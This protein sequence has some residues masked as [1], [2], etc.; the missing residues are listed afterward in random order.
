MESLNK[1]EFKDNILISSAMRR[2]FENFYLQLNLQPL[3]YRA[4]GIYDLNLEF[5][6]KVNIG[7]LSYL[8]V[9]VQFHVT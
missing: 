6:A 5:L 8:I 7:I 2:D 4:F 1:I 9:M 3:K